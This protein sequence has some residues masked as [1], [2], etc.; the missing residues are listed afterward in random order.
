[1]TKILSPNKIYQIIDSNDIELS[2]SFQLNN[3]IQYIGNMVFVNNTVYLKGVG[4][5][6]GSVYS[7][8]VGDYSSIYGLGINSIGSNNTI[9]GNLNSLQTSGSIII[10]SNITTLLPA[11]NIYN[12]GDNNIYGSTNS[13]SSFNNSYLFGS[14]NT[15]STHQ[16]VIFGDNID[17]QIINTQSYQFVLNMPMVLGPSGSIP[18]SPATPSVVGATG[19]P[20]DVLF[21]DNS[22]TLTFSSTLTK[23]SVNGVFTTIAVDGTT[24]STT[25]IGPAVAT[26]TYSIGTASVGSFVLS[27]TQSILQHNELGVTASLFVQTTTQ[28]TFY[29]KDSTTTLTPVLSVQKE[30][31]LFNGSTSGI[32]FNIASGVNPSMVI[33]DFPFVPSGFGGNL[34]VGVGQ[35]G[36]VNLTT[37]QFNTVFSLQGG[38][39]LTTGSGNVLIGSNAGDA[40]TVDSNCVFIGFNAGVASAGSVGNNTFIGNQTGEY[41]IGGNGNTFVGNVAGNG[42]VNGVLNTFVGAGAGFGV[43]N[44]VRNTMIGNDAGFNNDTSDCTFIGEVAGEF[45]SGIGNICIGGFGTDAAA[46]TNCIVIGNNGA[47]ATANNQLVLGSST[48]PLTIDPGPRTPSG[49]YLVININGTVNY[50]PL[51][52]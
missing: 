45:T 41:N 22:G 6:I 21:I 4:N 42:N 15:A 44:G 26:F 29:Y 48:S 39:S 43:S 30:G 31:L 13:N 32:Y 28:S 9:N 50:L 52:I 18:T 47:L 51:Y 19:P 23:D 7:N 27:A 2:G 36:F 8:I 10:G 3:P 1:M 24:Q 14:Y 40:V 16:V 5:S 11:N 33:L 46:F 37:G 34:F 49:N 38:K 25:T 12:F 17:S 35:N 20:T